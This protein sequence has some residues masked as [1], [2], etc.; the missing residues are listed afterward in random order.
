MNKYGNIDKIKFDGEYMENTKTYNSFWKILFSITLISSCLTMNSDK[1]NGLWKD[2]GTIIIT[3]KI[4]IIAATMLITTLENKNNIRFISNVEPV[5]VSIASV[6][7]IFDYYVTQISGSQFLFRVWWMVSIFVA[8]MIVFLSVTIT[9]FDDDEYDRFYKRFWLGFIPLYCFILILCF[10]RSPFGDNRSVNLELGQG[11]FLMLKAFLNDINV[12]FEAPLIFFGNLT[13]FVPMP[14][15]I[16]VIAKKIKPYIIAI[17]GVLIPIFIE[18]YQYIFS[19]GD[20]DVDDVILNWLGFFAG[21]IILI[22]MKKK[23]DSR[24]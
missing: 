12:S 23:R 21:L 19:C 14:F 20:V 15:V 16:N 4:I 9:S 1:L 10:A 6:M 18:G 7:L 2:N 22:I 11:T 13:I 5:V 24:N 3:F 8:E 17:I